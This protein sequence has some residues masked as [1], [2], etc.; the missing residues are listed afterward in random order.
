MV[1]I[2]AVIFSFVVFELLLRNPFAHP[3]KGLVS[4]D[5]SHC[6]AVVAVVAAA[7]AVVA[8][9]VVVAVAVAVVVAVVAVVVA[10]AVAAVVVDSKTGLKVL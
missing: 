4:I 9:V 10:V 5:S 8:A 7:V 6:L 3:L 2:V 1:A